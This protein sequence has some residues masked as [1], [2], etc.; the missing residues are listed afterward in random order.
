MQIP[1][2]TVKRYNL[3][4]VEFDFYHCIKEF[5]NITEKLSDQV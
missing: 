3:P 2:P 1:E 5:E 4:K